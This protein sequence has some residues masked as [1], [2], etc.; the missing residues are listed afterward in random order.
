MRGRVSA[1]VRVRVKA[2]VRV[3]AR[4][5][6]V[7]PYLFERFSFK[8]IWTQTAWSDLITSIETPKN[9]VQIVSRSADA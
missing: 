4:F 7:M 1:N 8:N 9:I 5:P 6:Y 3:S 2:R